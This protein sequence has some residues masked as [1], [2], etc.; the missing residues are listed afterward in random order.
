[1]TRAH[2]NSTESLFSGYEDLVHLLLFFTSVGTADVDL[3]V[4]NYCFKPPSTDSFIVNQS[5]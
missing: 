4:Q 5:L 2:P 1:M 3:L